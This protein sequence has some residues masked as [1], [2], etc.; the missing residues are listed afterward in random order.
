MANRHSRCRNLH[1]FESISVSLGM[2]DWRLFVEI[3]QWS[4]WVSECC[5]SLCSTNE[6]TWAMR[7]CVHQ[8]SDDAGCLVKLWLANHGFV[9]GFEALVL[10]G[11]ASS[12]SLCNVVAF[13]FHDYIQRCTNVLGI[14][15]PW[16]KDPLNYELAG[17][18]M[19]PYPQEISRTQQNPEQFVQFC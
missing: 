13:T 7:I 10:N 11:Y 15:V 18:N 2:N 3:Q 14:L 12:I 9:L 1:C 5:S 16:R 4:C 17:Q 8:L 19:Y 6:K